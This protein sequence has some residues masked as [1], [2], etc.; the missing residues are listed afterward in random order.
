MSTK[1]KEQDKGNVNAFA[2][3]EPFGIAGPDGRRNR[4]RKARTSDVAL[5]GGRQWGMIDRVMAQETTAGS[6]IECPGEALREQT[7]QFV[8]RLS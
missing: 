4:H 7:I 8:E 1:K 3:V 2:G 5:F 6:K